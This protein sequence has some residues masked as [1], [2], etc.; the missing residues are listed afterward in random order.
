MSFR[1]KGNGIVK[2]CSIETMQVLAC[3][4]NLLST[5]FKDLFAL[6]KNI[7]VDQNQANVAPLYKTGETYNPTNYRPV[8]LVCICFRTLEHNSYLQIRD[9]S[10]YFFFFVCFSVKTYVVGTLHVKNAKG[11]QIYFCVKCHC[12]AK[13]RL[14]KRC[15]KESDLWTGH[16]PFDQNWYELTKVQADQLTCTRCLVKSYP[17]VSSYLVWSTCT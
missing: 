8:S 12:Q 2:E 17:Q 15:R 6:F 14:S 4:F 9:I 5:L 10:R 11:L 3:I 13:K 16:S 1:Q 7:L